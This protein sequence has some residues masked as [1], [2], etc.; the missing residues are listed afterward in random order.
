MA[1][2]L[3]SA[4]LP[5]KQL[6]LTNKIYTSRQDAT[7]LNP[8]RATNTY[9]E[10]K[11]YVFLLEPSDL[12]KQG[13]IALN[14]VHR[15]AAKIG[16]SA[17]VMASPFS[18]PK[19][20]ELSYIK[21]QVDHFIRQQSKQEIKGEPLEEILKKL[22]S[23]HVFQP[24]SGFVIDFNSVLLRCTVVSVQGL[25]IGG[26][27]SPTPPGSK[28]MGFFCSQTEIDFVNGTTVQVLT[29]KSQQRNLFQPDFNFSELGIGGLDKEF[30]DIFRRAFA[31]RVFP[32]HIVRNLGINHVRGMLLFGP[33]GTGKTLLARQIGKMLKAREPKII[34]GPEVLNKFV[35]QS[36]ENIRKLF[37]DAEKEYK[38]E[39][40]NSQLHIIIF[41]EL[42]CICRARGSGGGGGSGVQDGV[43]NQ[44]LSKIDGVEALNNILLIGMTNRIDLIDDALTRPG[45][46]EVLMEISLP[47]EAGRVD[48]LN[49]HTRKM[50]EHG[51]LK[52]VDLNKVAADTK[53]FSGAELEGLVR[54][55]TSFALNSKVNAA[56]IGKKMDNLD[57]IEVTLECFEH[58]KTEILPAFGQK[59]KDI[60]PFLGHGIIH[61]SS[62]FESMYKSL[63]SLVNQVR[64]TDRQLL[65]IMLE[66]EPGAGKTA[67]AT[68][69]AKQSGYPFVRVISLNDYVG[70]GELGRITQITKVFDDAYK[71]KL[72]III[73]DNVERLLNYSRIGPRFDNMVLQGLMTIIRKKPPTEGRKLLIMATTSSKTFMDDADFSR[74]FDKI[75]HLP[76][77]KRSKDI[78]M[79]LAKQKGFT[80]DAAR[81]CAQSRGDVEIGIQQ[82]ITVAEMAFFKSKDSG[83]PLHQAFIDC[84]L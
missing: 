39:G 1:L 35:G 49:I 71:S 58:A 68:H 56:N 6:A 61:Y 45:R 42:D 14:K 11:G 15:E 78:S 4:N 83:M 66:G 23:A 67:L 46:M 77:L 34:N 30:G 75:V 55:A 64:D 59:D 22:F 50:R 5:E 8:S 60:A 40:E 2:R 70:T 31:S 12:L 26:K 28:Q 9:V 36:E 79:V 81:A 48:I 27:A 52:G 33:P 76:L 17:E 84:S 65:S 18:P 41:D 57:N 13:E 38:A 51:Y 73:L 24:G 16:I 62:T 20:F 19:N 10:I 69:L 25:N 3:V 47:S 44:L 72:S 53:N 80:E 21:L 74:C 7:A 37:E 54:S 63:K 32:P 82:L 29:N 43:V